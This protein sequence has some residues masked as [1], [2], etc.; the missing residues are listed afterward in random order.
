[1]TNVIRHARARETMVTVRID[2]AV[3]LEIADDGDGLPPAY[4]AGVGITSMRERA[5]EVGGSCTIAAR[6]PRG[7]L[8]SAMIPLEAA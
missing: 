6:D 4:R 7:T 5:A 8:V 1:M 3:R 2:D